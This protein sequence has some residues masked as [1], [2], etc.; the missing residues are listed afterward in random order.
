LAGTSMAQR[1]VEKLQWLCIHMIV[2]DGK[3]G[4]CTDN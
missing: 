2:V 4:V 3:N 1:S